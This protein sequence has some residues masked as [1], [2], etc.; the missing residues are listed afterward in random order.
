MD[1]RC[2][3][4]RAYRSSSWVNFC[5]KAS[6]CCG[7]SVAQRAKF[8]L[9]GTWALIFTLCVSTK[10][11]VEQNTDRL[12]SDPILSTILS[13]G[14]QPVT[15]RQNTELQIEAWHWNPSGTRSNGSSQNGYFTGSAEP[16]ESIHHSSS[17][18]LPCHDD[19]MGD[20]DGWSRLTDAIR[21]VSGQAM[22]ERNRYILSL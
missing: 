12:L 1:E 19:T 21:R 14:W 11:E 20:G 18:P 8:P 16:T 3:S 10:G 6:N 7:D 9:V 4:T 2:N 22:P 13:A 17:Y 5:K 15:Y